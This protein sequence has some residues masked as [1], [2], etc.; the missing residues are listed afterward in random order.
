MASSYP[1]VRG[2]CESCHHRKIRCTIPP[3]TSSCHNCAATGVICVFAPRLKSGRPRRS[4][5]QVVPEPDSCD[6]AVT[7]PSGSGKDRLD[8][9]NYDAANFSIE[10]QILVPFNGSWY[11]Y[12]TP[13]HS[14]VPH[15]QHP[16]PSAI[17]HPG[18]SSYFGNIS[19]SSSVSNGSPPES[20]T[21][22]DFD[23]ALKLCTDLDHRARLM[24]NAP[25]LTDAEARIQ[26]LDAVCMASITVQSST[27]SASRSI[28]LAVLYKA[29]EMCQVLVRACVAGTMG[30]S[31]TALLRHLLVMRRLD[32]VVMFAKIYFERMGSEH[33]SGVKE[34]EQIHT[35]IERFLKIDYGHRTW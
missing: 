31:H 21:A 6:T 33:A 26:A 19:T 4:A 2:A 5:S 32:I 12:A 3:N 13:D 28:V 15:S 16:S 1:K 17:A 24:R 18:V 10:S 30:T 35:S 23:A 22:L 34:A 11:D 9:P 20:S 7:T 29:L 14:T 8:I 25:S 27:D